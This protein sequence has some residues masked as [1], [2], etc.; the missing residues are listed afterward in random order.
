MKKTA[1]KIEF[2][3][4]FINLNKDFIKMTEYSEV[5]E[6]GETLDISNSETETLKAK[7]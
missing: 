3:F 6:L 5:I 4:W 7:D 1:G 2:I